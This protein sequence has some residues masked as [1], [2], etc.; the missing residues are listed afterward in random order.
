MYA[1][2]GLRTRAQCWSCKGLDSLDLLFTC[3]RRIQLASFRY[4]EDDAFHLFHLHFLFFLNLCELL[5]VHRAQHT[6]CY[7]G[8]KDW[9]YWWWC[10]NGK[11]WI[12]LLL[13]PSSM[14]GIFYDIF[15]LFSSLLEFLQN[16][17]CKRLLLLLAKTWNWL[18]L[19][20][21]CR[22]C[23]DGPSLLSEEG[24]LV[25]H[26]RYNDGKQSQAATPDPSKAWQL[27]PRGVFSAFGHRHWW[28]MIGGCQYGTRKRRLAGVGS[29]F[30]CL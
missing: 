12:S 28:K 11:T 22:D 4:A 24:P 13:A 20:H 9:H 21:C 19:S 16:W 15:P 7:A 14:S 5:R 26:S 2:G 30:I 6:L 10:R 3:A 17:V 8:Q 18:C 1:R 23:V 25:W 27:N 29:C